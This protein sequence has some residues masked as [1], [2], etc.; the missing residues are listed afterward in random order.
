MRG[1]RARRSAGCTACSRPRSAATAWARRRSPPRRSSARR[2]RPNAG[3]GVRLSEPYAGEV[4]ALEAQHGLPRGLVHALMRQ[5]SA[6]DPVVVSPASAVGLMQ[7]M[8]STAEKAAS[9]LSLGFDLGQL[10]SA[11]LNLRLGGFYI[12]KLL[13]TFEGSLPLAAAACQRRSEGRVALARWGIDR[14]TDVWVARIPYDETRTYVGRVL[15][16]LA[17]Y[18]WL[19]GGDA[20][21]GDAP[22]HAPRGRARPGG[23]VLSAVAG[24][25]AQGFLLR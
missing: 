2:L 18:Q 16:N 5:E 9:E 10:K 8:P 14:D 4:R 20:G 1:R 7:L 19:A 13:R 17:R 3:R 12:G 24:T 22:A 23:R 6:F 25:A 15:S 11:P 21:R